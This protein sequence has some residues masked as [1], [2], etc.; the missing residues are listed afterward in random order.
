MNP[1]HD[2]YDSASEVLNP[3]R[4]IGPYFALIEHLPI[5]ITIFIR[6]FYDCITYI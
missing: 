6:L 1:S 4:P 5:E 3:F 2:I